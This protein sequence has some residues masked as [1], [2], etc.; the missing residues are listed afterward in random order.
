MRL[1][2]NP[3]KSQ[4]S[5]IVARPVMDAQKLEKTVTEDFRESVGQRR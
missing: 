3:D 1:Y 2:T 4:W 5:E